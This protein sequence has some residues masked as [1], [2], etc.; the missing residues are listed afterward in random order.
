M[1]VILIV[2]DSLR[3]DHLGCYGNTWIQT[4]ALDAL[5]TESIRFTRAYPEALP[6]I[7]A[8]RAIHTGLRTFPFDN[9]IPEKGASAHR[10][11]WQRIPDDQVTL[12]E[13]LGHAGYHTA[14]IS[15]CYHYF[16]PTMNFHRGFAQWE[17]IRGQERDP[18]RSIRRVDLDRVR[19]VAPLPETAGPQSMLA[20]YLAN[21]AERRTEEDWPAPRVFRAAMRWVSENRGVEPFFLM[22]DSFDPHE[23]WDPPQQYVDLYD[24]GYAGRDII[25]PRYGPRDY[26]TDAELRHLRARYAGEVTMVDRWLG[27]FLEWTRALG[28]LRDTLLIVTSDHGHQLGEHGLTGKV[29]SGLYAELTDVPLL[30]RYP[31]RELGGD[32]C[33][34][35]AQNHD[36]APTILGALGIAAP[37]PMEGIDLGKLVVAELPA[38]QYV[39]AGMDDSVWCRDESHVY[40]ARNDGRDAR[41]F[42]LGTDPEQQKNVASERPA[43]VQM[44]FERI[45]SDAGGPLPD[46]RHLREQTGAEWWELYRFR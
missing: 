3:A 27:H 5:A 35:F 2:L 36:L 7:P 13:I 26:L 40:F 32:T 41:L 12:A 23:P 34:A 19:A 25:T 9:W 31:N 6:T 24:P 21:A 14:L 28:M 11:G 44:M 4:L 20:Q 39:T 1:N 30:L 10:Y 15:D 37:V 18:Y 43:V 17:W 22:I 38:R 29:A 45:L 8:R 16:K 42:D 46:Y 33:D